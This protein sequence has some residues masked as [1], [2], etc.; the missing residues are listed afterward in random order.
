M[1][2][3]RAA[4]TKYPGLEFNRV[5][6]TLYVS[7]RPRHDGPRIRLYAPIGSQ[8]FEAEYQAAK[9]RYH[10]APGEGIALKGSA[11]YVATAHLASQ[12]FADL[13]PDVRRQRRRVIEGFA[14]KNGDRMLDAL[15]VDDV[16]RMMT[17]I[18]SPHVRRLWRQALSTMCAWASDQTPPLV[19]K[20]PFAETTPVA[21]PQAVPFRRWLP[22]HVDAFRR[23][24]PTGTVQRRAL[25]FLLCTMARGRSDV[26][27]L[28]R[29]N[30]RNGC[31]V[32]TAAKNGEEMI[33]P[34]SLE[35]AAEIAAFDQHDLLFFRNTLGKPMTGKRFG[36]MF[37]AACVA[38]GLDDD[39]TAHGLR[40]AGAC[41]AAE[42]GENV[43]TIMA[44][45]GDRSPQ[46]AMVYVKQAEKVRMVREY[47]RRRTGTNG[48]PII[49][50]ES[51]TDE[52][53]G[54]N[55]E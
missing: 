24:W 14:S 43:P 50:N 41:E 33:V 22:E 9:A 38:A 28:T 15:T 27:R 32:F 18:A 8:E 34:V 39:L 29:R 12:A 3:R 37:K 49:P 1:A 45:L 10:G 31:V 47:H 54:G 35:L 21:L 26:S 13:S 51:Q 11:R 30:I 36:E 5:K 44:L 2:R 55:A 40:H 53:G 20:N 25:E 42:R 17:K 52:K 23:R 4:L 46:A 48:G 19:R 7:Y 6:G 16:K